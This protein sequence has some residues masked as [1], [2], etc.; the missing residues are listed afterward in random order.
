M[1]SITLNKNISRR[2]ESGHPW[3]FDNEINKGKEKDTAA[4]PGEIVEVYTFDKKFI[5]KGLLQSA[6]ANIG[7]VA[8]KG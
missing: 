3:I 5:G 7:K 8:Y 2:V 4:K 1:K 6:I